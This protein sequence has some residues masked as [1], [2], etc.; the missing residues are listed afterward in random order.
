[1]GHQPKILETTDLVLRQ[2]PD[3]LEILRLVFYFGNLEFFRL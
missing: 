2:L 3:K 1:M